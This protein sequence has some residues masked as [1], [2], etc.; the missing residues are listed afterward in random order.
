MNERVAWGEV[1]PAVWRK[2]SVPLNLASKLSRVR[3]AE[4]RALEVILNA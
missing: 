2:P 1:S 3:T 4:G